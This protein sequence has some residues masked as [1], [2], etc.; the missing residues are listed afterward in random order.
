ME[1]RTFRPFALLLVI[2]FLRELMN[3]A[4]QHV[5]T[6][7]CGPTFAHLMLFINTIGIPLF[8]H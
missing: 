5:E 1:M 8:V 7:S 3:M 4:F 6:P 2:P